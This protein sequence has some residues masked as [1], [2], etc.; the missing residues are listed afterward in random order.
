MNHKGYIV[1]PK[2]PEF[3]PR[4]L[5]AGREVDALIA[6]KLFGLPAGH[7]PAPFSTDIAC[8]WQVV[9]KMDTMGHLDGQHISWT[10]HMERG[11]GPFH[12]DEECDAAEAGLPIPETGYGKPGNVGKWRANFYN[13]SSNEGYADTA[14][15]AICLAAL[16]TLDLIDVHRTRAG[17]ISVAKRRP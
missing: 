3:V 7:E 11:P 4:E 6:G 5:T 15:L 16:H 12:G 10:L 9:E 13:Y 14:P 1:H 2:E 17:K 8:A